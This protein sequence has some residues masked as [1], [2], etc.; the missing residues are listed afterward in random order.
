MNNRNRREFL[1]DVGKGMLIASVGPALVAE[2]GLAPRAFGADGT[3]RLTFGDREPLV[4]LM[5]DTPADK[6]LPLLADKVKSGTSLDALVSAGAL[7]NAR[8]FGGQDY[9]GYH[10]FMALLPSYQ[11]SRELPA[12]RQALPVLKVLYRNTTFMQNFGGS[13][14]EVLHPIAANDI[15][16]E[17]PTPEV[18]REATR[19]RDVDASERTF[20]AIARQSAGDAFNSVVMAVQDEV[21]VH[22][23]VLAWRAYAVLDLVGKEQAHTMLRQSVRF[24]IHEGRKT[25]VS[26]ISTLLPKLMDQ[27]KLAG[28][29]LGT[30]MA[31]D[32]WLQGMADTIYG[33][34]RAK[35]AE[36][37]AAALAEGIAPDVVAEA[38]S[39]GATKLVQCMPGRKKDQVQPGKPEGSIHGAGVGVHGADAANAWRNIARV[40]NARN[41]I[42]SLIVGAYHTA[43]QSGG[44]LKEP[45]QI[46]LMEKITTK[47]AATLLRDAEG[48]L[49]EKNLDLT[50]ALIQRYGEQGH[51]PRKAFDMLLRYSISEDGALHAEKYYRTVSEDFTSTRPAYRW[52]HLVALARVVASE[53]GFPAPGYKEACELLKV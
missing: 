38:M 13:K 12:E 14:K 47:D 18:L 48:A 39:L 26:E 25:G 5:Q 19:K 17:R 33:T 16:K 43:G 45:P 46:A 31:D 36:A 42:A 29:A 7:A 3:D 49:K 15:P 22:R 41:T 4:A 21:D 37:V 51:D 23:T 32:A 34:N 9:N 27:Y 53:Y 30:K 40:S 50:A 44:L 20:A 11:M 35:A 8:T 1:S 10:A 6:L 2:L 52:R 28:R 24:C